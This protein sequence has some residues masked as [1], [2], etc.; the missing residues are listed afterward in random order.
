MWSAAAAAATAA[1]TNIISFFDSF[2]LAPTC[3]W[4]RRDSSVSRV[5]PK[6]ARHPDSQRHGGEV[7]PSAIMAFAAARP[8]WPVAVKKFL[9]FCA[10]VGSLPC[11]GP[12]THRRTVCFAVSARALQSPARATTV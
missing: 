10:S 7:S 3:V 8:F 6:A 2:C 5:Y 4:H 1:L 11:W 9:Y 12:A